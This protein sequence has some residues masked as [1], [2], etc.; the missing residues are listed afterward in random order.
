MSATATISKLSVHDSSGLAALE[1]SS[2]K[3]SNPALGL[4]LAIVIA[5]AEIT[6]GVVLFLSMVK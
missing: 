3:E 5:L 6:L 1:H 2:R 4:S